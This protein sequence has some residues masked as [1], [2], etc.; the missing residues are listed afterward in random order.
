MPALDMAKDTLVVPDGNYDALD[1]L[2][3]VHNWKAKW[4][5]FLPLHLRQILLLFS[6]TLQAFLTIPLVLRTFDFVMSFCGYE[7]LPKARRKLNRR[8]RRKAKRV[9]LE[10][11]GGGYLPRSTRV[12]SILQSPRSS[13]SWGSI[14]IPTDAEIDRL[15]NQ[16]QKALAPPV[17]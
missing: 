17:D 2:R 13:I 12:K 5:K 10:M 4:E 7:T 3:E 11:G 9:E 14:Q 8:Y 15:R 1:A 6:L 16:N